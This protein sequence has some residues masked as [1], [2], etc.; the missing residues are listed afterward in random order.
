M[1]L[2]HC[3]SAYHVIQAIVHRRLYHSDKK[4]VLIMAD[5]S[6]KKFDNYLEL[7]NFFD[8][9]FLLPYRK[10]ED[11]LN[12]IISSISQMYEELVPHKITEFDDIYVAAAHY[13]FSLYLVSKKVYFHFFEDGCGILSKPKVSYD[14][15][16]NYSPTQANIAQT[17]G[18][19]D[20]TNLYVI[21][22]ICNVNAQSFHLER[23]RIVDFDLVKEMKKCDSAYIDA[24]LNFFRIKKINENFE[25]AALVFTQQLANLGIVSFE[26]QITIYQLAIDFFLSGKKIIFKTHPDDVMYYSYL[27]PDSQILKGQYPAE[28]L[29]FIANKM[30][31]MSFTVF[32]SSL[33]SIWSAFQEN[34]YCGYD[35]DKTYKKIDS[36]YFVL[37]ILKS[38][39]VEEYQFFGY[40]VDI[41]LIENIL[42]YV[43]YIQDRIHFKYPRNL[44]THTK[45]RSVILIDDINF[46]SDYIKNIDRDSE[47][48]YEKT[49]VR[50]LEPS[51]AQCK[52]ESSEFGQ[53]SNAM[54]SESHE[55]I[56]FEML[57]TEKVINLLRNIKDD[58]VIIFINT[59]KDYCFYSYDSKS[60]FAD[61]IPVCI[62]RKKTCTEN[63]Y[64]NDTQLTLYFY[65]KDKEV[66]SMV[67]NY[68]NVKQLKNTGIEEKV[69]KM[70]DEQRR[71]AILEGLLEATEKRLLYY[72]EKEKNEKQD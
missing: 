29:P 28:L 16:M 18:M 57:D 44:E 56:A 39:H 69:S 46:V 4:S 22:C 2:Y 58:D 37:D 66:A 68:K 65:T 31:E 51:L 10:I 17:Y 14:I 36:Y 11:N 3:I 25:N 52:M 72:L 54:M 71:I 26:E 55:T 8:E 7:N 9:I 64:Y 13:Y 50:G 38:L 43:L 47:F 49:E 23:D 1:V 40:G 33:R 59:Q 67:K 19:F 42:K 15:V 24:I 27:F 41:V 62:E 32:S 63:V 61:M 30:P 6:A 70:T 35:F 48:E 60:L 21:D 34:I 53:K 45:Q 5:F 20:G 12:T